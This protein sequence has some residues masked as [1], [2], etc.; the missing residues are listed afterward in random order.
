MRFW[1]DYEKGRMVIGNYEII[2]GKININY[3]YDN[4]TE[5][6]DYSEEKEKELIEK[7]LEQAKER[8]NNITVNDFK[9]IRLVD[10]FKLIC[11]LSFGVF[12]STMAYYQALGRDLRIIYS[13]A[14][15]ISSIM[16]YYAQ[17]RRTM[18]NIMIDE[19]TKYKIYLSMQKELEDNY[20]EATFKGIK[21]FDGVFNINTLDNYSL[22]EVKRIKKN[23]DKN[24]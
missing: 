11:N 13:C 5:T 7:M 3:I 17:N 2:D 10:D 16:S 24:K 14:I 15:I 12:C 18:V 19:L 21:M 23:L 8:D 20:N 22:N 6:I 9:Q 1:F 4:K